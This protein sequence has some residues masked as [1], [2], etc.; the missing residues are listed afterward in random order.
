MTMELDPRFTFESFVVGPANRLAAAAARRVAEVPG[1]TYNPLFIYSG[2]GLGKTHLLSAIGHHVS[3]VHGLDILYET[4]EH[5]LSAI[6]TAM[7]EGERDAFRGRLGDTGLLLLDDVQF[8]AGHRQPQEELIRAWDGLTSR[9]GQVVLSSDRPP[10]DIDGLDDRLLSRLS[11]GLIV[12]MGAPDFETRVAIARRKADERGQPLSP[13]VCQAL[14]RIAFTNVRELQGALNRLIA[15]QELEDRE[16]QADEVT[17]LL[18]AAAAER[19]RDEFGEFLSEIT[20]TVGAV[21]DGADRRIA[22][23]IMAWEGEGYRTR[24][25]EGALAGTVTAGQADELVRRFEHDVARLREI[26]R[27]IGRLDSDARELARRDLLRD[28]DRVAEAESLL[29]AVRERLAP[30]PAPPEGPGLDSIQDSMVVRAA[31]AVADN[32]GTAYN[33]LF[34]LTPRAGRL[35]LLA[36]AANELRARNPGSVVAFVDGPTFAGEVIDALEHNQLDAWRARYR[37]ADALFL[38]DLDALGTTERA[39]EELFHLFEDV[40][41]SGGQLVFASRTPPHE[42]PLPPRLRSRLESGLVLEMEDDSV[43]DPNGTDRAPSP[44]ATATSAVPWTAAD[45]GSRG[46][47]GSRDEPGSSDRPGAGDGQA[48]PGGEEGG[49][50]LPGVD[51]VD[52]WLADRER[53]LWE[54][55]YAA[56]WLEESLD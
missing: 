25:L 17:T 52:H 47:A 29:A 40:H 33:P 21:V 7:E 50:G 56:D 18:G 44:D 24:R 22:D 9:G 5:L 13:D 2:S 36:A 48:S 20:G 31:R 54:W 49:G 16:V 1:T 51:R 53:M 30:P 55:P 23:A 32:P 34:L 46:Q 11:G 6:S 12:D 3:R 27:E 43:G 38:D 4:L 10:Q 42:L 14:G 35:P 37:N 39:Q 15:V 45:P 26:E 41:R 8:L 19:G 28:P